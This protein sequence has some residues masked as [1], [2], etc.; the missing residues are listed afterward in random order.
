VLSVI[1]QPLLAGPEVTGNNIARLVSL[2]GIGFVAIAAL[3]ARD[4]GTDL[5][6]GAAWTAVL[7]LFCG[8]MHHAWSWPGLWL[9]RTPEHFIALLS[10]A[11]ALA[12]FAVYTGSRQVESAQILREK[13]A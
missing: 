12:G 6:P 10:V 3:L 11:C 13:S 1:A 8:S 5:V 4:S 9:V 2:G 7:V